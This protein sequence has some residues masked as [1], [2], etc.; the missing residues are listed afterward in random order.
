MT[1]IITATWT[2][3]AGAMV[4][5]L[6]GLAWLAFFWDPD[7]DTFE[8]LAEAL[9]LSV[10][11]SA[12]IALFAYLLD[13]QFTST[14]IIAVYVLLA[15]PALWA[16]RR[17]WRERTWGQSNPDRPGEETANLEDQLEQDEKMSNQVQGK[18]V[19]LILTLVFLVTLVWRFYQIREVVLPL[20]VDSVHHVQIVVLFLE[21]GG[22]PESLEPIMPVT[23][24]YHYAFHG[25]A[26]LFSF[27]SSLSPSDAVLSLGQVLNAAIALAV[28]RL[29]KALWGGWRR[30]VLSAILVAFATQMPAYYVTWGRYTL[31]T[32]MLLLPITMAAALDMV[33]KGAKRSR[34]FTFGLLTAGI[35]LSHYFAAALLAIFLII[36]GIQVLVGNIR[37]KTR[38]IWSTWLPLLLG[39]LAGLIIAGPWLYRMWGYAQQGVKLVT[40]QPNLDA[41]DDLYFPDYLTYLWRLLGP[42][43]SQALLFAALPG[44]VISLFRKRTRVFGVW[45]IVLSVLSLPVGFYVAPF[46]PDHAVIVLFLPTALLVAELLVSIIDWSPVEKLTTIKVV[47]VLIIFAI[48]VSW[49][50]YETRTVINSSTVLATSDDLEALHWIEDN[51]PPEA[52]FGINVAHWQYGSYRGIDGGWWITPLTAR[53]TSLPNVLYLMGDRSY[54]EGINAIALQFSQIAGCTEEFWELAQNDGLTHIYLSANRGSMQPDQFVGCPGVELIFQ[55]ESVFLYRIEYIIET[56]SE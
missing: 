29:G 54:A 47:I 37:A 15:F 3:I 9:G 10:S 27:F 42:V 25:M 33:N 2:L 5:F 26:A 31:L 20:W 18:L 12:V 4:L 50:I 22:I 44:L 55:N 39:A 48:L 6:P 51:T 52:R 49:G 40:I 32:G 34:V 30:A 7:Q 1:P 43:R 8:R 23:F 46:R 14:F 53:M 16:L 17:W 19:Y 41:I 56:N 11:L 13:W 36:L 21:N 38:P 35:L 45:T 24:Y 28:Y